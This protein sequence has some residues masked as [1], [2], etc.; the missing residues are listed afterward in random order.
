[1]KNF[2]V[3]NF[4]GGMNEIIHPALLENKTATLLMDAVLDDGKIVAIKMPEALTDTDPTH[5]GHYGT[6]NRSVVKWYNRTYWS[7]ND[8]TTGGYYGGDVEG[9]GVPYPASQP[10]VTAESP[11]EGETGLTGDFKYCMC[12]VNANGWEG[13]PGSLTDYEVSVTL[14]NQFAKVT[15][16]GELPA[17]VAYIKVYRTQ[18]HGADF[19][20]VGEIHSPATYLVDKVADTEVV[21]MEPLTSQDNYPPPD[22]GKYLTESG[23][24]FFLAVGD[25]LYFSAQGNPHAWPTLNFIGIDNTISGITPEFQGVLVFTAN[26]TFRVV[27]AADAETVTKTLIPG[28]QG[29]VNYRSIAHVSNAP[30]WLSNDGICLWDGNGISLVSQQTIQTTG[31]QVKYAVSANDCYYLFLTN[32]AI[33]FDRRNG[34]VFHKL[35]FSC[36]YAWYD[37]DADRMYLQRTNELL[38]FAAGLPGR[39]VYRTPHIGGSEMLTKTYREML[40]A[41]AGAASVRAS[42]DGAELFTVD[43]PAVGRSRIKFPHSSVGRAMQVEIQGLGRLDELAVTYE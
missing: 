11:G 5:Y 34:D 17:G 7:N 10:E 31:L 22:R 37:A 28:N 43:I 14:S 24:V 25:R 33:V 19:Y 27:G 41:G 6:R 12:Y 20:C 8:A 1:M 15:P 40:I 32:G 30:I 26:N 21:Y 35:S 42:L 13:A 29:C 39:F 4:S 36:E 18:D 38:L 16:Q 9:L 23:G 2:S 3:N